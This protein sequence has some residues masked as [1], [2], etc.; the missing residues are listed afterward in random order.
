MTTHVR[1][2]RLLAAAPVAL[3]AIAAP[4][5][6]GL[7]ATTAVGAP[8][9]QSSTGLAFG[10]PFYTEADL[11][12][13]GTVDTDDLS[14]LV[15][16]VGT[17]STDAGWADVAAADLDGSGAIDVTD[18]AALSQRMLYDDG[19]FTLLEASTVDIQKAMASGELTAVELTQMYLDRIEA[20]DDQINS[21]ITVN[22]H[23]LEIAA[24]L[25]KERAAGGPRSMLHGIPVIAK[26]NYNTVDMPTTAGCTCLRANQTSSDAQMIENLR[27]DGAVILAKANLYEFA[28]N[29]T[30]DSSL[31]GTTTNP[32]APG[33][34]SGGSSG[35]SGASIAANFAVIGLGTD[36]GGSIRIPSSWNALVGV[37]STVGLTSRDG[38]VPLALSQDTGGPMT[39]TVTDAA[40]AL[41]AVAGSDPEDAATALTD[42]RRPASYTSF[43][44][45]DSLDGAR[46]G[47]DPTT[48][49]TNATAKRLFADAVADLEARGA[50]VVPLA[51]TDMATIQTW[52]S[53]STNEFG[54]DLNEYLTKFA[55]PAVPYRSL[56]DIVA[57]DGD[58]LPA[59]AGTL[60]TRSLVTLETYDAW[61]TQ[62]D[63]EIAFGRR[64]IEGTMDAN[65]VD[66]I[67]YPST[68]GPTGYSS[69]SNN[70]LSPFSAL[71]AVTVPMGFA[72]AEL[73]GST[74][75]GAPIGLEFIGRAYDEGT[76]LG[77][78]YGYEQGSL[79][80][81]APALFPELEG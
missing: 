52:S 68:S 5:A 6:L 29:T 32:Y 33:K 24:E 65:D 45:A 42:S 27:A 79:N 76:L 12:G 51:I 18:V 72:S 38:I 30:T 57:S 4:I 8:A 59:L 31:G 23:A 64:A 10:A 25:D 67:I 19:A 53:G 75:D 70:R 80:R 66:A 48:I 56:Q 3:A 1:R 9:D 44:D 73:D 13:D 34:T 2:R 39:R 77:L 55:A 20:Y 78:A 62:H 41:D 50:E 49:G 35:G 69:G 58:Y 7:T 81:H 11:T 16:A 74:S 36:T 46:I 71:P 60:R 14:L 40:I 21:I 17:T 54:H 22:P 28:V 15:A 37:R 47:Y 61:K 63:G 26:D 43:L